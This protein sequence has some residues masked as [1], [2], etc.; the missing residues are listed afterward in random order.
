MA[1][2]AKWVQEKKIGTVINKVF[3]FQETAEAYQRL[4]Q[5]SAA[6]KIVVQTDKK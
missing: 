5:G 4:M 2:L 3:P 6:G 1:H